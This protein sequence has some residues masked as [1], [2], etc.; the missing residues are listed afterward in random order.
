MDLRELEAITRMA[1]ALERIADALTTTVTVETDEPERRPA[2]AEPSL[3]K[4]L[5][6]WGEPVDAPGEKPAAPAGPM[7]D[8]EDE[9]EAREHEHLDAQL[10]AL[11][12]RH[13]PESEWGQFY[14]AHLCDRPLA[15][16]HHV[17]GKWR[18][19]DAE[20]VRQE[21]AEM[22]AVNADEVNF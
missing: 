13:K 8:T 3:G 17:L 16:K 21:R 11:F 14:A 9:R 1:T 4:R 6:I 15:D 22:E 7:E 2:P 12:V 19:R 18:D 5:H 20:R 10:K